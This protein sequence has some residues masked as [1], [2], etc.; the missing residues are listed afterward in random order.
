MA[1]KC[2]LTIRVDDGRKWEFLVASDPTSWDYVEAFEERASSPEARSSYDLRVS[3]S[4]LPGLGEAVCIKV[5]PRRATVRADSR[6]DLLSRL[7]EVIG[8]PPVAD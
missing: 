7:V 1:D 2:L 6:E 4:P 5:D 3:M 8:R